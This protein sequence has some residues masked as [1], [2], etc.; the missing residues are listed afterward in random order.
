MQQRGVFGDAHCSTYVPFDSFV[1]DRLRDFQ[2]LET[3][4][5]NTLSKS[6]HYLGTIDGQSAIVSVHRAQLP[7]IADKLPVEEV[8]IFE[9]N[10]I[11]SWGVATLQHDPKSNPDVKVD[12]IYP[13]TETHIAKYREQPLMTV[14]ETPHMYEKIVK[15]YIETMRGSR[16]EWVRAI[17]HE[18]VEADQV[19]IRDDK[20]GYLLLPNQRWDRK[21]K[22]SLYLMVLVLQDDLASIRDLKAEHVP[23]LRGIKS[24]VE[25]VVGEKYGLAPHE[26]KF[27]FHY[28]PSYYH[29]HIHVANVALQQMDFGRSVLLDNVID[30]LEARPQG[31]H[32]ATISYI[33]GQ[34]HK[35]APKLR[36][37]ANE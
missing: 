6:A 10:G 15:P 4:S 37:H 16:I 32:K 30:M 26:L 33:L 31:L 13:A 21:T 27:Y 2:C 29:M 18:G 12:V 34:G 11:Y 35:L 36:R 8:N 28:Q 14:V 3:L 22:D 7:K 17:I 24:G 9:T 5:V 25:K 1:M 23:F 19:L 20:A